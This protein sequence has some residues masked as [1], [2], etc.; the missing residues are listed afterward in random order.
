MKRFFKVSVLL[1]A[2]CLWT[3]LLTGCTENS[4]ADSIVQ[5][6]SSD[7]RNEIVSAKIQSK[8]TQ[9][10]ETQSAET[11]NDVEV[12]SDDGYI[13]PKDSTLYNA[14]YDTETLI[15]FFAEFPQEFPVIDSS[16]ARKPITADIYDYFIS[17][18]GNT[19]SEPLCSKTHGAWINLADGVAD[20]VFLVAPTQSEEDY[21][22]RMTTIFDMKTYGYDGLAFMVSPDCPVKNLTQEQIKGIYECEITNWKELGG[23][24][25]EIHPYCRNDESG[26][27]RLFLSFLWPDGDEPDFASMLDRFYYADDMLSI[28]ECIN[29]D[30]YAIGY[31][32]VS[33]LD[34]E[35]ESGYVDMVSIDGVLPRTEDF[36]SGAYPF[37]TE[38]VVA[39]NA[40]LSDDS[41]AR[42]LYNW[43][44]SEES[45]EIIERNSSLSVAVGESYNYDY[46]NGDGRGLPILTGEYGYSKDTDVGSIVGDLN[47][48]CLRC[49]ELAAMDLDDL[50]ILR[51]G[52]YALSG[53]KFKTEAYDEYYRQYSWYNPQFESDDLIR[54]SFNPFQ[55]YNIDKIL[56]YTKLLKGEC[57]KIGAIGD[58]YSGV[59]TSNVS[60]SDPDAF[61]FSYEDGLTIY[62]LLKL[63]DVTVTK[64]IDGLEVEEVWN[65]RYDYSHYF[66]AE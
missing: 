18:A 63:G 54:E 11:K 55:N 35:F 13:D 29:W 57:D 62:E 53:K 44:G 15:Q 52:V 36:K 46:S 12:G 39:V 19:A 51:N 3:A 5:S 32:I 6:S 64:T 58:R 60:A 66:E 61:A 2:M 41:P 23:P 33:Y 4:S 56:A 30:P 7:E 24:D 40:W 26:S 43:I 59:R 16:T 27:Q 8:E 20:I 34:N 25:H 10:A 21:F 22:F 45:I 9:R 49:N 17:S 50:N 31:N 48:R 1:M 65:I 37:I 28:T 38:S 14:K 42:R 47:K